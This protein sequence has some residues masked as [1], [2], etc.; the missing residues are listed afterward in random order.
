MGLRDN[1]NTLKTNISTL[2]PN[3]INFSS[4]LG[5]YSEVNGHEKITATEMIYLPPVF[6]VRSI[7]G[8]VSCVLSYG[9]PH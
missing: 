1:W 6:Y 8:K 4:F 9:F 2:L 5:R 7:L 3:L